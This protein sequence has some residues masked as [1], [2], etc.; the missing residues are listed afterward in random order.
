MIKPIHPHQ[1]REFDGLELPPRPLPT[2]HLRLEEAA[3]GFSE[4]VVIRIAAAADRGRDAGVGQPIGVAHRPKQR[5]AIAAMHDVRGGAATAVVDRLLERIEHEARP[6]RR[7][8]PPAD[9]PAGIDLD[10]QGDVDEAAPR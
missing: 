5:A 4:R 9:D 10:D 6:Q 7:G 1:R 8:D 2:N 3:D